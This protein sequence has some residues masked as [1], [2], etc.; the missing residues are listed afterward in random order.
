VLALALPAG[1]ELTPVVVV[2]QTLVELRPRGVDVLIRLA[3][4]LLPTGSRATTGGTT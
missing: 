3:P 1:F 2:T 4:K